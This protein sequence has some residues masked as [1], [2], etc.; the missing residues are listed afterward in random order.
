M[1]PERIS[2]RGFLCYRDP[3][4]VRFEGCSLW[5]L[6]GP[7]GSGKSALFDAMTFALYGQHRAGKYNAREL[8]NKRSDGLVIE[9]DFRL[10]RDLFRARRTLDRAG[11]PT[12]QLYA[13]SGPERAGEESRW[14]EIADTH[15]EQGFDRWI[16]DHVGL[17]YDMFTASVLLLQGKA[18]NLLQVGPA[19]RHNLLTQI[20][21]LERYQQIHAQAERHWAEARGAAEHLRRQLAVLPVVHR[22]ELQDA[23]RAMEDATTEGRTLAAAV[24][25]LTECIREAERWQALGDRQTRLQQQIAQL[26]R[27]LADE[28]AI[29]QDYQ[30]WGFLEEHLDDLIAWSQ[31]RQALQAGQAELTGLLQTQRELQRAQLGLD[32]QAHEVCEALQAAEEELEHVSALDQQ[33]A[34]RQTHFLVARSSLERLLRERSRLQRTEQ[35]AAA[36]QQRLD[37]LV[38]L[39]QRVA[40]SLPPQDAILIVRDALAAARDEQMRRRTV[41]DLTEEGW[42]RF[43][44][45]VGRPTCPYCQQTLSTEYAG[46]LQQK[47]ELDLADAHRLY[48]QAQRELLTAEARFDGCKRLASRR[49]ALLER[50]ET[51]IQSRTLALATARSSAQASRD[52]CA[53]A[54]GELP[55]IVRQ[56]T[57]SLLTEGAD[58]TTDAEQLG[59]VDR[60]LADLQQR[61]T[62]L[63]SDAGRCRATL[64]RLRVQQNEQAS[65]RHLRNQ[66][67]TR[68]V[69]RI[70]EVRSRCIYHERMCQEHRAKLPTQWQ[71]AGEQDVPEAVDALERERRAL[72][73]RGIAS[74]YETLQ[75]CAAKS[76]SRRSS[77]TPSRRRSTASRRKHV[78]RPR[79][80]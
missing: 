37:R 49:Q 21:G 5:M 60:E 55:D 40:A 59:N 8:I 42:Q 72:T 63:A 48:A 10:D 50:I 15:T 45:V 41:R 53:E 34:A 23:Q 57:T 14:R 19:E 68:L 3:Q 17:T 71:V 29:E 38:A 35:S 25:Q 20:V 2:V 61:R 66:D 51:R 62:Q 52:L 32:Q 30:R 16:H 76:S 9:I 58:K 11:R 64:R 78:V 24:E 27:A 65:G 77:C 36:L 46:Q 31:H 44:S 69:D 28:Q 22:A 75:I 79:S 6:A 73:A 1:I 43:H 54:M 70:A 26:R 33:L 39:R 47:M 12:R 4:E 67:I 80:Y 74:Q 13:W 56:Q 18:D 7:N